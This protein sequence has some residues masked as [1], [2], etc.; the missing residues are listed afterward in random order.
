M[1]RLAAFVKGLARLSRLTF[2]DFFRKGDRVPIIS[3]KSA[4]KS[5]EEIMAGCVV[6]HAKTPIKRCAR[7]HIPQ[8][9]STTCQKSDW[10]SHKSSCEPEKD[11][12]VEVR[13]RPGGPDVTRSA[14]NS[15]ET[16]S[17]LLSNIPQ[18]ETYRRLIDTYRL[19][20]ADA[21]LMGGEERGWT[22]DLR[23]GG[24]P[25]DDFHNFLVK[26]RKQD[27][28]PTWFGLEAQHACIEYA[29]N[30]E[31]NSFI[32]HAIDAEDVEEDYKDKSMPTKMRAV[33]AYIYGREYRFDDPRFANIDAATLGASLARQ[34]MQL[35]R[36][37]VQCLPR[38]PGRERKET[39]DLHD[40]NNAAQA[41]MLDHYMTDFTSVADRMSL[42]QYMELLKK[43]R[44]NSIKDIEY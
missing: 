2:V 28:L 25:K 11:T 13:V 10:K 5:K 19:R 20:A 38:K 32:G 21:L 22:Y 37:G 7:C 12:N 27:V 29:M 41:D 14:A 4:D 1:P 36:Q 8:Y 31:G 6:C 30:S 26:A 18:E 40:P 3:H 24:P 34:K 42:D 43:H 9:C 44:F 15:Q 33:A 23:N 39:F 35:G 17:L 16:A